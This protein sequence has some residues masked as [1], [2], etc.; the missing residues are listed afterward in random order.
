MITVAEIRNSSE[1]IYREVLKSGLTGNRYFPKTIRSNKTLS[2]DF[3]TM[4]KE[5][6]QIMSE[7]KDRTGFGYTVKSEP[8]KTREHGL[9]DIP[10]EIVFETLTDYLEFRHKTKEYQLFIETSKIIESK[11]PKLNGLLY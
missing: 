11:I 6:A 3:V 10:T 4:S 7:S 1:R 8:V 5:I 2:K 9:Q